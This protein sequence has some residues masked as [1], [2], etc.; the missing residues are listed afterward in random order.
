M[1]APAPFNKP[2]VRI[3]GVI[4]ALCVAAAAALYAMHGGAS[5]ASLP[6][7]ED[8]ASESELRALVRDPAVVA[9]G[10]RLY[11]QNCTLCHGVHGQGVQGPNLRDDFWIGGSDMRSILGRIADGRPE[12]GMAAWRNAFDRGQLRALAAFVASLAGSE[13]GTGKAPEGT[14]QPITWR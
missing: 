6:P 12:R 8:P 7:Y 1:A 2:A 3:G 14:R 13:D 9:V 11:V 5:T 10:K 4:V